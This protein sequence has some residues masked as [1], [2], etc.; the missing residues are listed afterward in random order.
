[1]DKK[2]LIGRE[3]IRKRVR[4]IGREISE[5]YAGKEPVLIGIL[6]GVVFFFVELVMAMSIPL[7]M[8][9]IKASSYGTSMTSSGQVR[10]LKDVC[11]PVKDR[12]LILID[13]IVDTGLTLKCILEN[14]RAREP[15]SIR[16]CALIDRKERREQSIDLDY[17]G[18]KV[19]QGFL[20]GYGLDFNEQ[21]RYLP[22]IWVVE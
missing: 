16:I 6:N 10:M 1:M 9:F 14:L 19:D 3:R 15:A 4:E 5:D 21:Y 8:D 2:V 13:D 22:D 20:V 11:I 7:K 17:C 12:D 18:F